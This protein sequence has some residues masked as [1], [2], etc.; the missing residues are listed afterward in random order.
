MKLVGQGVACRSGCLQIPCSSVEPQEERWGRGR[1]R[2]V[3]TEVSQK[4]VRREERSEF[5]GTVGAPGR[6][7][8]TGQGVEWLKTESVLGVSGRSNGSK[9]PKGLG[10]V[11]SFSFGFS[12]GL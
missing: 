8:S 9:G 12:R 6:R 5:T 11:R 2:A 1:G 10:W 7:N 3:A 4:D